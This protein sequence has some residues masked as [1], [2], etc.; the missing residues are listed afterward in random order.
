VMVELSG[1]RAL[2][3][4]LKK[5]K[6]DLMFGIPG[7]MIMP[8][9]DELKDSGI[10]HVLARHEQCAAHM[11][12][13]YAR[14]SGRTGV[15]VATSGPGATNLVTGIANAYLDSSPV[16]AL[17]GQVPTNMLDTDAFQEADTPGIFNS[18]TKYVF[19]PRTPSEIPRDMKAAFYLA[20]TGRTG[21]VV[22]DVPKDVQTK[23]E[24]M[25]FP[26]KV[27]IRGYVP[28]IQPDPIAVEKAAKVLLN[29][30][31]PIILA[32][33]GVGRSGTADIL[34]ALAEYLML[35][36]ATTL[37]GKGVFPEN[38]PLS[39]GIIGMHGSFQA[40]TAI[41]EADVVFSI[42]ARFS[43][44]STMHIPEFIKER[45]I[46]QF[47][48]DPTE[49]GK[50]IEPNYYVVGDLKAAVS[51][52]YEI[53]KKRTEAKKDSVWLKRATQLKEQYDGKVWGNNLWRFN[54]PSIIKKIREVL[55][56]EA[57]VT[58]EVGQNQMWAQLFYKVM[59]P[60][61]FITSGGLGTMGFGFP[62]A[63]GAKAARP[64]VPVVDI[65]GDG[66]FQMTC[67]SLATS[68]LEDLPV[69]VCI[70]NNSTLGMVAQWQR[71]FYDGRYAA[72]WLGPY[73]DFV[74]L[75]K[76]F[77]AEGVR[78]TSL[79][80]LEKALKQALRNEVTTVID[81]P[82]SPDE[83]VFPFVPIG[84]SLKDMMVG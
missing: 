44:R 77:G 78:V 34:L 36:V 47:D 71:A 2:V 19:Q 75:A 10:R 3:E 73:P 37:M 84:S 66:S 13:G 70:I 80:E 48:I 7:G 72:T 57:I 16:V 31:K 67:N 45:K 50:N 15:V 63:I 30:E 25:V 79:E 27:E 58:T 43:D 29:A 76:A 74:Q 42:G 9:Y 26:D 68:V 59:R 65:A 40:N 55:P 33:G 46:I 4:S 21:P 12:D 51:M 56:P 8:F 81:M 41:M 5:E 83:D 23:S 6:V 20:S 49:I 39:I 22:V 1:A 11:A 32:G 28:L 53:V 38:H 24:N 54:A 61:L 52:M 18:I 60:G 82:I 62:A 17:T 64:S 35:P 14:V 69:I